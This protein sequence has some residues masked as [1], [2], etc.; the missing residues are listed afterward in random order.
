MDY[1]T[2]LQGLQSWTE[3]FSAEY[4]AELPQIVRRAEDMIY[5]SV[6]LPALRKHATL[7]ATLQTRLLAA[8]ADFLSL[9]SLAVVDATGLIWPLLQKDVSFIMEAF[10]D[11]TAYGLPRV[12]ALYD[13]ETLLLGPTPSSAFGVDVHYFYKPESIVTAANTWLGDNTESVLF[14]GCLVEAYTYLK[15]DTELQ[16]RY[17]ARYDEALSRLKDLGEGKLKRDDFRVERPRS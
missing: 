7:T 15:G 10:P 3:T 14:Y 4:I 12:Y 13:R 9:S 16:A 11:P 1:A 6:Q 17:R 5:Q 8:P 2:L